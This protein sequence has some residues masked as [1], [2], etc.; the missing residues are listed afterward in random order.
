M[1]ISIRKFAI[2]SLCFAVGACTAVGPDYKQPSSNILE[3]W[4]A[5]DDG[6]KA[7]SQEPVKT[8][9][10]TVFNDPLLESYIQEAVLHNND[11]KI[12]LANIQ[13]ARAQRSLRRADFSPEVG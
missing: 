1:I 8:D 2:F 11:I 12:A 4:F 9:W 6:Q 5:S 10:W 3:K 7:S 13:R